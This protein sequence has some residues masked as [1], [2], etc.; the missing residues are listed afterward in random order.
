MPN[1]KAYKKA[2]LL[3]LASF[4]TLAPAVIDRTAVITYAD[5]QETTV[6]GDEAVDRVSGMIDS[7]PDSITQEDE[8]K[9]EEARAEFDKLTMAQKVR[10]YNLEKLIDAESK[11]SAIQNV[12]EGADTEDPDKQSESV[13]EGA[14]S[15]SSE[16]DGETENA[17]TFTITADR[18]DTS[19][20]VRY[21]SDLDG[22]GAGDIPEITIISPDGEKS[23]AVENTTGIED[24]S[25]SAAFSWETNY[26][27]I[28]VA[29]AQE[30]QWTIATSIPVTFEEMDY[31]GA[32]QTFSDVGEYAVSASNGEGNIPKEEQPEGE[33][34]VGGLIL[35]AVVLGAFAAFMAYMKKK[36]MGQSK[37]KKEG[38][39]TFDERIT[40]ESEDEAM[41]ALR[42]RLKA[43]YEE[44][45]QH[46]VK[47]KEKE[48]T[49]QVPK[50]EEEKLYYT[51]EEIDQEETVEEFEEP[52]TE[53]LGALKRRQAGQERLKAEK[54]AEEARR[55]EEGTGA[56]FRS[57]RFGGG[58]S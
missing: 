5:T 23:P 22:D 10:V 9:V 47:E 30:G 24:S 20:V 43:E 21:T 44:K 41:D 8:E 2:E 7:L 29:S 40:A 57:H 1:K 55:K 11:L 51:Q 35:M 3:M 45:Q 17:Y 58:K 34:P 19:I 37:K 48:Q 12:N 42:D 25:I 27:Q 33:S 38:T 4:L 16:T 56:T 18:P 54:E 6:T 52:G 15:S 50:E 31:L 32:K 36:P 28:D 26:M 53:D 13:E 14:V 49:K 39:K 46:A